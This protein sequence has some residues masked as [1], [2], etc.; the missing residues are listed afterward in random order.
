MKIVVTGVA[1][2]I[3]MH[4]AKN[5][6]YKKHQ[7][8]GIDNLNS[9]YSVKLKKDRLNIIKKFKKFKF[10]KVD[11]KNKKKLDIIFK[12]FKPDIVINLAAQ[13]GV[14]YSLKYPEK[15]LSTNINGFFNI[16]DLS[17]KYKTKHFIYASSSSVY[18][19]KVIKTSNSEED[20]TDKPLSIYAATKKCNEH[21]AYTKSYLENLPTTGIRFF[22]VYGPWGRPDM[23]LF[24]FTRNILENKKI[25]VYNN[26]KMNRSFTYIDDAIKI[27]T[28]IILKIP[29]TN[30]K[31]SVP[32]NIMN[33]GSKKT[34]NLLNF[35]NLIEKNL[36]KKSLKN[37]LPLQDGDSVSTKANTK[38]ILS[39]F[40]LEP[41]TNIKDGISKFINWYKKYYKVM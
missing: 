40:R 35:I 16:I 18:G 34:I 6:L 33:I 19:T 1:G 21:I 29:N 37:Y 41:K 15:Y 38:K 39:L 31:N 23:A 7:V 5:L 3:G 14:R 27:L 28:K 30:K 32:F 12:N 8:L 22:T 11:L 9:Y 2:F 4:L 17:S 36:N 20:Q 13:A 24:K 25:D 26:G 10:C